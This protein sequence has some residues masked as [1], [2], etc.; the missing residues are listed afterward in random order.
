MKICKWQ[1]PGTEEVRYYLDTR[2]AGAPFLDY[3][4]NQLLAGRWIGRSEDGNA[5]VF[6]KPRHGTGACRTVDGD[7]LD[8]A[9]GLST[10]AAWEAT[11]AACQTA[12]GNFSLAKFMKL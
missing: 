5:H 4:A 12:S 9:F 7:W 10:W 1:R 8:K 3:R 11:F 6:A 2:H